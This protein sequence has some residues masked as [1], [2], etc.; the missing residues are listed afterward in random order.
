MRP[1]GFGFPS[2]RDDHFRN[3]VFGQELPEAGPL[4]KQVL[5]NAI[6]EDSLY[7]E[8]LRQLHFHGVALGDVET[9]MSGFFGLFSGMKE[10]ENLAARIQRRIQ[11]ANDGRHERLWNVIERGPE[12]HD[13]VHLSTEVERLFQ[14]TLG[15]VN[16]LVVFVNA[17]LPGTGARL[18]SQVGKKHTMTKAGEVVD[19]GG[20]SGTGTE[21]KKTRLGL[22]PFAER[23]PSSRVGGGGGGAF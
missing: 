22:K 3:A 12:Q 23:P 7:W 11:M 17:F 13:V 14:I 2:A 20:R 21:D 15:V 1:G 19:I 9:A 10:G 16:R 8:R 5:N 18:G 4:I 6:G